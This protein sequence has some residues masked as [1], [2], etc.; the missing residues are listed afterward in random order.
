M[1]LYNEDVYKVLMNECLSIKFDTGERILHLNIKARLHM[2][3]RFFGFVN[4]K[5][6][7]FTLL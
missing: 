2:L 4:V 1:Y 3:A 7:R 6:N 5:I